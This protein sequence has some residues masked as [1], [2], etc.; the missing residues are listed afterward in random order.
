MNKKIVF[1]VGPLPPPVHGF[2]VVNEHMLKGLKK[3][4]ASIK[5]FDL[6]PR[7]IFALVATW[8]RFLCALTLIPKDSERTL[9]LPLSG[10]IRQ[11]VDIFF[12]IPSKWF[13]FNIYVHHHS[14][15]YLN[16]KPWFS[17]VVFFVLKRENHITLCEVMRQIL[18]ERYCIDRQNIYVLSNA[19]FL[20]VDNNAACKSMRI[21]SF[22]LGFLSNITAEKGIFSFL[23]ACDLLLAKGFFVNA[24]IAG[25]V[26]SSIGAKFFSRISGCLNI[27]Y[28]GAVYGE[29][30]TD[31]FNKLDFFLFPTQY[32]NE[33]EPVVLWEALAHSVPVIAL[34]RGCISGIVPSEAGIIVGDLSDFSETV[35]QEMLAV[36]ESPNLLDS[37]RLSARIAFE[38]A[39]NEAQIVLA[40]LLAEIGGSQH[41]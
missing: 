20:D 26:D 3:S 39:K 35:V 18:S 8:L 19:A 9:Y 32:Y 29:D 33:A 23:D 1:F 11:L 30:K 38:S 21:N 10:G 14:F 36:L 17:R 24:L 4:G 15:S 22:T 34:Q 7:S 25:P 6:S 5:V 12:A 27:K 41:R 31:F 13:G 16:N 37:R 28:I 2:S 40:N